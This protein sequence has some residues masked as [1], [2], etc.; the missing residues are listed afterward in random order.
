M[1]G[2]EE[3]SSVMGIKEKQAKVRGRLKL[4]KTLLTTKTHKEMWCLRRR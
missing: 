4:S 3:D 2:I 1:R